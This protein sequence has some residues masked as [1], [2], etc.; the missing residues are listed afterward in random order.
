MIPSPPEISAPWLADISDS[1]PTVD[2]GALEVYYPDYKQAWTEG[3]CINTGPL[4]SGRPT[5]ATM[6]DCCKGAYGGQVSGER[7][8]AFGS[9]FDIACPCWIDN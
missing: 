3:L 1:S 4:P 9:V 7:T 6:A 2:T 8:N 5:Y